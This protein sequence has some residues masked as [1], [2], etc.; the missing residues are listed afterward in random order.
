MRSTIFDVAFSP[1]VNC[2][3][4]VCN[5]GDKQ[6]DPRIDETPTNRPGIDALER[7]FAPKRRRRYAKANGTP[8][9]WSC[10]DDVSVTRSGPAASNVS[11]SRSVDEQNNAPGH[12]PRN[13]RAPYV[14]Q[15]V[16]EGNG[17]TAKYC[18][19]SQLGHEKP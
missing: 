9:R 1:R 8:K 10:D 4:R 2:G 18:R 3:A 11:A 6:A 7:V 16:V 5:V 14:N 15:A 12:A 13:K 17:E 19:P